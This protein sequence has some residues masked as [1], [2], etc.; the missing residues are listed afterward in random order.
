M[1]LYLTCSV[2][3]LVSRTQ[4]FKSSLSLHTI[5]KIHTITHY[6]TTSSFQNMLYDSTE[7][8]VWGHFSFYKTS[9]SQKIHPTVCLLCVFR[10]CGV[11][12][13][14]QQDPN[15]PSA[16]ISLGTS[17]KALCSFHVNDQQGL[18]QTNQSVN[19]TGGTDRLRTGQLRETTQRTLLLLPASFSPWHSVETFQTY[20]LWCQV[21]VKI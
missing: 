8:I 6:M 13:V 11:S 14:M 3:K 12:S 1:T 16:N 10:W 18:E 19:M 20:Y 4:T 2:R 17:S 7:E 5:S 15:P 9:Y 21:V